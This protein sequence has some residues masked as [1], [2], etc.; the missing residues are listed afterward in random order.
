MQDLASLLL[1]LSKNSVTKDRPKLLVI[2]G[3][4]ASGK[5]RLGIQIAKRIG[6]EIV[7][8]DSLQVYRYLDIGTAKPRKAE[9]EEVPHH[10]IDIIDPDREFNAGMYRKAAHGIIRELR[11]R[12]SKIIL[13]GGT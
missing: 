9:R 1:F 12:E 4:T 10:L 2:L 5:S 11:K 7:N 13:V 6:G 3:P 8:A